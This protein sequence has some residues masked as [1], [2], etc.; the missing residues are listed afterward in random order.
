[1]A[2]YREILGRARRCPDPFLKVKRRWIVRR[3]APDCSRVE[4][5][6]LPG[7]CD[8]VR[9]LQGMGW[10]TANVHLG[11]AGAGMLG[12]ALLRLPSD[13]LKR[14]AA[15]V[16]AAMEADWLEWR[17]AVGPG[18]EQ[19]CAPAE[20]GGAAGA[21]AGAGKTRGIRTGFTGP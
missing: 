9:L 14:G 10:E 11:S 2:L 19:A 21:A 3:L 8:E 6:S 12:R 5:A 17:A 20:R 7:G 1:M 15:R 16:L 13:W 4:L 18:R